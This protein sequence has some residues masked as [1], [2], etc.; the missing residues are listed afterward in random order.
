M[1]FKNVSAIW[2]ITVKDLHLHL[3]S[4]RFIVCFILSVILISIS[5]YY[6]SNDYSERLTDH[7]AAVINSRNELEQIEALS[8]LQPRVYR[9]PVISSIFVESIENNLGPEITITHRSIPVA[10]QS[11]KALL[12][13]FAGIFRTFDYSD[14]VVILLSL[15]AFLLSYDAV[16]GE[17]ERGL[18]SLT[19]SNSIPRHHILLGKYLGGL[20]PLIFS[21]TA[22]MLVGILIMLLIPGVQVAWDFILRIGL[23]YFASLAFLSLMLLLGIIVSSVTHQS[24]LSLIFL[25]FIWVLFVFIIPR[26]GEYTALQ[27]RTV[28]SRRWVND[29]ISQLKNELD[30]ETADYSKTIQPQRAG[31]SMAG[32]PYKGGMLTPG[33]PPETVEYYRQLCAYAIPLQ[34]E[35]AQLF[36][37]I[38]QQLID[39]QDKQAKLAAILSSVSP[40]AIYGRALTA[41]A[42]TDGADYDNFLSAARIYRERII[43]YIKSQGGFSSDLYF[44]QYDYNPT[45][46]ELRLTREVSRIQQE[47]MSLMQQS[48]SMSG[49][50]M[51]R[52]QEQYLH[53]QEQ[54]K[55]YSNNHPIM[56]RELDLSDMPEFQYVPHNPSSDLKRSMW[57]LGTLV[58]LNIFGL[59][60]AH[61][62]F[63][64][65][66]V[67]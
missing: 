3:I 64:K 41:L 66:D 43:D 46:E 23:M 59:L 20:L 22:G 27:L 13:Q 14:V 49:P 9:P 11:G 65:Y 63:L 48:V 57:S 53:A 12:N 50:E 55:Q 39:G 15:L 1:I 61:V 40:M 60:V 44:M 32:S 36:R 26:V 25:L 10:S 51:Q 45:E 16:T 17:K 7:N 29:Q 5:V 30:R 38:E 37:N 2:T 6:R 67:R 52:L 54:L 34:M 42:G 19:L 28:P 4:F 24:F 18:L 35:Y 31:A 58:F 33:N 62:A 47:G 56:A 8:L 21:L